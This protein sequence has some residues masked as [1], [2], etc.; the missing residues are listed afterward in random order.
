MWVIQAS[1]VSTYKILEMFLH[2]LQNS[3]ELLTSARLC[4]RSP[5]Y[6]RRCIQTGLSGKGKGRE[7]EELE[8]LGGGNC[9]SHGSFFRS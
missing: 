6:C 8:R 2:V 9:S 3:T 1:F 5:I 7:G 4:E